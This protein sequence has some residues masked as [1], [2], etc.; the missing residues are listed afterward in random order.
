MKA[1]ARIVDAGERALVRQ[2]AAWHHLRRLRQRARRS[3]TTTYAQAEMVRREVT[4]VIAMLAW[5]RAA[6]SCLA[7]CNQT[8]IEKWLTDGPWL[9][10]TARSFLRWAV[11]RRHVRAAEIPAPPREYVPPFIAHDRRWNLLRRLLHDADIDLADRVA[12][13]LVLLFAQPC[14]RIVRLTADQVQHDGTHLT[15]TMGMK[16]A[17]VPPP[18]DDLLRPRVIWGCCRARSFVDRV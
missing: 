6:G 17:Q 3:G 12:G 13:L 2:F 15:L 5:L 7:A 1:T 9:R 10:Y 11:A 16:P 4:A 14:S 8:E 18:V